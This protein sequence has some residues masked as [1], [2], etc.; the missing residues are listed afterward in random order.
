MSIIFDYSIAKDITAIISI[1]AGSIITFG[2]PIVV[3]HDTRNIE[4]NIFIS[5]LFV[6]LGG[7]ILFAGLFHFDIVNLEIVP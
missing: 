2:L 3:W 5:L 6:L 1:I 7:L 4:T